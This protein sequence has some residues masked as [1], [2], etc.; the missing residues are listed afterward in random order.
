MVLMIILCGQIRQKYLPTVMPLIMVYHLTTGCFIVHWIK[1]LYHL[2]SLRSISFAYGGAC[3]SLG[4]DPPLYSVTLGSFVCLIQLLMLLLFCLLT[5]FQFKRKSSRDKCIYHRECICDSN[6]CYQPHTLCSVD[7]QNAG[8]V[9][10]S[11]FW[12]TLRSFGVDTSYFSCLYYQLT[13]H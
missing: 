13:Q 1:V 11:H 3:C 2:H 8:S 10:N 5:P 7:W 6:W 12:T 4:S 9:I